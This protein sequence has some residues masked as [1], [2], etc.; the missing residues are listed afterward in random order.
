MVRSCRI[1]LA[2]L[3][4]AVISSHATDAD[5][6]TSYIF[7]GEAGLSIGLLDEQTGQELQRIAIDPTTGLFAPS[8][9][10]VGPDGNIYASSFA[11][12]QI[13]Y[14]DSAD[15]MALPAKGGEAIPGLFASMTVELE[16]EVVPGSGGDLMFGPDGNLYVAESTSASLR[17]F[18]GETG[19]PLPDVISG[20]G[21]ISGFGFD[22][23]GRV[24][25]GSPFSG[26]LRRNPSG[27]FD[28]IVAPFAMGM[29]YP[30][31]FVN[32]PN[33]DLLISDLFG[34]Q[35]LRQAS[36][37][38]L[39]QFASVPPAIPDPLPDG[40]EFA[41]NFPSEMQIDGDGNLLVSLL[42]L[43]R[44]PDNRGAIL[45]FDLN[46]NLLDPLVPSGG[47]APISGFAFLR[48]TGDY[49]GD[50]LVDAADFG[51]WSAAYGAR[52]EPGTGADGNRDGH[53]NAADFT[54]WRDARGINGPAQIAVPEP[55]G[56]QLATLTFLAIT[57]CARRRRV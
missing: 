21:E 14:F 10:V 32:L 54:I 18:D 1:F 31:G 49:N 50:G 46:G 28:T 43:T 38:T 55:F 16:G 15:G 26:V 8:D 11:T 37:G 56:L 13:F 44:P 48:R 39:S 57:N 20:L 52:V 47:S 35:I 24:L 51:I 22:A 33:G 4:V 23:E 12:G 2:S 25:V 7:G 34:N 30:N 29:Q 41:S 17:V 27:N 40:I 19:A 42:G 36:D 5:L 45:R 53:V 3:L 6:L 9:V